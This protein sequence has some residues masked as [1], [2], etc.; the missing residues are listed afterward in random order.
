MNP[1]NQYPAI[2]H[3]PGS[4]TFTTK[5]L[6]QIKLKNPEPQIANI[7]CGTGEQALLLA[8]TYRKGTVTA[9][10]RNGLFFPSIRAKAKGSRI[11]DRIKTHLSSYTDL[12]FTE[13]S[14]D[15]LLSE[16]AF[17]ELDFGKRLS[18]WR[19]YIRPGGYLAM[20]EL[21]LL[22][23]KELPG[24]VY[25]YFDNAFHNRELESIDYH[26]ARIKEAG[27]RL[28]TRFTLPD[29]C[30][31]GYFD[32]MK[33]GMGKQFASA[34]EE[35]Q[36]FYLTYKDCFAYVYFVMRRTPLI[37]GNSV[38]ATVLDKKQ[39][40]SFPD[41]PVEKLSGK[42]CNNTYAIRKIGLRIILSTKIMRKSCPD[43]GKKADPAIVKSLPMSFIRLWQIRTNSIICDNR[44][45]KK[46]G[47]SN[48]FRISYF[49]RVHLFSILSNILP[50]G[51]IAV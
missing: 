20:S 22:T 14:L 25:D 38:Y 2:R 21:C 19:K 16:G 41:H 45:N 49:S 51:N 33:K 7:V 5:V 43:S 32:S 17:E 18:L 40:D 34:I 44:I 3:C 37:S 39:Q 10:D 47:L 35:E 12:P 28:H 27:Y 11:G 36:E 48:K 50:I 29:E 15:L 4:D 24:E 31:Y 6:Q 26:L 23:D 30:W 42:E 46:S 8:G 9:V 13:E 1:A